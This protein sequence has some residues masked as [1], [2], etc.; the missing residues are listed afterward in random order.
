MVMAIQFNQLNAGCRHR[1]KSNS[2]MKTILK[3]SFVLATL[4]MSASLTFARK[5][6]QPTAVIVPVDPA[7]DANGNPIVDPVVYNGF[8]PAG[9]NPVLRPDG[10]PVTLSQW[11]KTTG[12]ASMQCQGNNGTRVSV[13]F[14]NLI[15]NGVYSVWVLVFG[16]GSANDTNLLGVGALGRPDGSQNH[17]VASANGQ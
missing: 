14:S 9:P 11:L 15:P 17:F 10:Q 12:T 2:T 3:C 7:V 1:D 4:I 5:A 16:P 6:V 13:N 8:C